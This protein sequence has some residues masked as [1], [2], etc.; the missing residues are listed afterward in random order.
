[1]SL[2]KYILNIPWSLVGV[3]NAL[4]SIPF[5]VETMPDA[6][7]FHCYSCG[8]AHLFFPKAR[9]ITFGNVIVLRRTAHEKI[10]EHELIHVEQCMR[11]PFFFPILYTV[12]LVRHGYWKNRFEIE[13]YDESGTWPLNR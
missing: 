11:Y 6:L 4:L 1:M 12:E 5:R 10:L 7:V 3:S 13:A 8:L 9:G 2:C